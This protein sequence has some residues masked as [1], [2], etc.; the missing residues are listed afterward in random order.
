[1]QKGYTPKAL[2]YAP[3]VLGCTPRVWGSTPKASGSIPKEVSL[4][5]KSAKALVFA[6][7]SHK[8]PPTI[9]QFEAFARLFLYI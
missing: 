2:G 5:T 7:K 3:R 9:K 8:T 6:G 4:Y 1:V